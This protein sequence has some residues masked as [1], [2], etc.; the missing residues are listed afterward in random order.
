MA[1]PADD[2]LQNLESGAN[3]AIFAGPPSAALD[4]VPSSVNTAPRVPPSPGDVSPGRPKYNAGPYGSEWAN[5]ALGGGVVKPAVQKPESAVGVRETPADTVTP[6][7]YQGPAT[8]DLVKAA[9]FPEEQAGDIANF[10]NFLAQ[11]EGH[12]WRTV[13]GGGEWDGP[14]TTHPKFLGYTGSVGP[15]GQQTHPV[16]PWQDEPDTWMGISQKY[17][18]GDTNMTPVNQ[19]KGN[20]LLA[21][22]T[23]KRATGRD[24]LTDWKAGRLDS[25]RANLAGEWQSLGN[26]TGAYGGGGGI[27]DPGFRSRMEGYRRVGGELDKLVAEMG[28]ADPGSEEMHALLR[29]SLAKSDELQER[30]LKLSEHPPQWQNPWEAA[31]TFTPLAIALVTM[32]GAFSKRPALAS[33]NALAGALEGL[34]KGNDDQYKRS[35]DL[36][37][38]QTG[39]ALKA[40][41]MQNDTIKNIFDDL[42]LTER[43]RQNRLMNAYRILG[44]QTELAAAERG[45]WDALYTRT[46]NA[47]KLKLD[48]EL[49]HAEIKEHEARAAELRSKAERGGT[50][51]FDQER[52]AL[53]QEWRAGNE[54]PA[55]KPIPEN[56]ER[57][58]TEKAITKTRGGSRQVGTEQSFIEDR[59]KAAEAKKGSALEPGERAD[60]EGQAHHDWARAAAG[61]RAAE[62]P[63]GRM[64]DRLNKLTMQQNKEKGLPEQPTPEQD[65]TNARLS[66]TFLHQAGMTGNRVADIQNQVDQSGYML[67]QLNEAFKLMDEHGLLTGVGGRL[68]RPVE[69]IGNMAFGDAVGTSRGQFETLIAE[70]KLW[71]PRVLANTTSRPM[72]AEAEQI[73]KVVRGMSLGDTTD[74]TFAALDNLKSLLTSIRTQHLKQ[75]PPPEAMPNG[76]TPMDAPTAADSPYMTPSGRPTGV[77]AVG[78]ARPTGGQQMPPGGAGQGTVVAPGFEPFQ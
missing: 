61:G 9:G 63:E 31:G 38:K 36:W 76:W 4:A 55:D 77:P 16:G 46:Q 29:R 60:V 35:M 59:V 67:I 42:S 25:I 19:V 11:G 24:L 66:R 64:Y 56:I 17:L 48:I 30:Y 21:Q 3:P 49:K 45:E 7:Q 65:L 39:M 1:S 33:M 50:T 18:G 73:D 6:R 70:L 68:M 52:H 8:P 37:D 51:M 27:V 10:M 28:R 53:E 23:Y 32:A 26:P 12:T 75:L 72:R 74:R 40:F 57:E 44:M 71:A 41:G 54:W 69:A 34:N 47:D 20:Y 78:P 13:Y 2:V 14:M 22:E 15:T 43:E 58:I 62:T 5:K